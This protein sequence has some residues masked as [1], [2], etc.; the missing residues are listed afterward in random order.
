MKK[1]ITSALDST[2][3]IDGI[4]MDLTP[5][6]I[7]KAASV[8]EDVPG[9]VEENAESVENEPVVDESSDPIPY[10]TALSINNIYKYAA[11][12]S[13]LSEK[14]SDIPAASS[15]DVSRIIAAQSIIDTLWKCGHFRVS[16]L[17]LNAEWQWDFS[18]VG[19]YAAFYASV[20]ST[21]W[22]TDMMGIRLG[23]YSLAEG[24][25]SLNFSTSV[26]GGNDGEDDDDDSAALFTEPFT[27]TN[28]VM[29]EGRK[30]PDTIVGKPDNWLI[31]IPFDTC[32]F[33]LGGSLLEEAEAIGRGK[34]PEIGD[35]D[36]FMDC[37]E[38]VREFVEDGIVI[39][40]RTVGRG[41][42]MSTLS[43]MCS[44]DIGAVIEL[45]TVMQSYGD[46]DL[47]NILFGEIPGVVIEINSSDFDYV[48]AE[49]LLQDVAY[50]P[51]GHPE[52]E[53]L[54]INGNPDG[55]I[56]GIIQSLIDSRAPEGED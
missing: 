20:E 12:V 45:G 43:G 39:S 26:A 31:Y 56:S 30:C 16:D 46:N 47:V 40:G 13:E 2:Y 38:V 5:R 4:R 8:S 9:H 35:T 6:Q 53:T 37:F 36:Y 33:R 32:S 11:E 55:G 22:Y 28:P 21:C 54:R 44:G 50:Y 1:H 14:A 29:E 49:L 24:G 10:H 48:D 41:G 42:L 7:L 27:T 15:A 3:V 19:S 17:V 18:N 25:H 34:A 23:G 51:L 52:G